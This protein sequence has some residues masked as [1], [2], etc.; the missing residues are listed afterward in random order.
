MSR[1]PKPACLAGGALALGLLLGL[2]NPVEAAQ[3]NGMDHSA[4]DHGA[5]P[6]M[7]HGQRTSA[8]AK[9][10]DHQGMG[11]GRMPGMDHGTA[12][13]APAQPMEHQGMDHGRMPGMSRC[14]ATSGAGRAQPEPYAD[15]GADRGR[16]PCRLS[17]AG[18]AQGA[19]QRAEQLLPARPVG[20]PGRRRRQRAGL[21]RQRLDRRRHQ[22][23]V[24]AQRRRTAR[25]QDRGRR[26]PG[27]VRARHRS[28]VGPGRRRAPGFQARPRRRPGRRS[29]CRAWRSHDFEAEV[30]AFLGE[31]GQSALRL[32][33]EYDILLTNRL[34]LQP[35]AEV[36]L[37]GRND[38]A[39]GIGSGLA[40]SELGLRLRYEIRR[41]FAP[42]IGVTWNRSYGQQRRP[43]PRR[44]RGRRR[45]ALRRRYP[46]CGSERDRGQ[47]LA[48]AV[49]QRRI[50][51]EVA[52]FQ[53][54]QVARPVVRA[55][56]QP[57]L[58]RTCSLT[59]LPA[60]PV[61]AAAS[62]AGHATSA[63]RGC[64]CGGPRPAAAATPA[65]RQGRVITGRI[66]AVGSGPCF[67]RARNWSRLRPGRLCRPASS[68]SPSIQV[69]A[70]RASR[71]S[72]GA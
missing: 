52:A 17:A 47:P 59:R 15:P 10:M 26:G 65:R 63:R 48:V 5:M 50:V 49:E 70:T 11:H 3:D 62:A 57:P 18:G 29:A 43:G 45:G 41:E 2:P 14:A 30:T 54:W 68:A 22:P 71:E 8:P 16:P 51:D 33:G 69:K 39:R 4:M 24:A 44:G 53:R 42:Y 35:S 60:R 31:N 19:R 7:D 64:R 27:A 21:G 56:V 38:P 28:L 61:P 34:I 58:H 67:E 25:R 12:S 46:Q 40:D 55:F 32:E 1:Q 36:N 23:P 72:F 20:I 13:P 66:G 9:P 6:G 37:Y